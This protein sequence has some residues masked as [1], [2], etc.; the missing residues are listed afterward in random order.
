MTINEPL[1]FIR[2]AYLDR[3]LWLLQKKSGKFNATLDDDHW[4]IG[5]FDEKGLAKGEP[6]KMTRLGNKLNPEGRWGI[7]ISSPVESFVE[8]GRGWVIETQ[9]SV[10]ELTQVN[11]V[12]DYF[13]KECRK[14]GFDPN[15]E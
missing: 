4:L 2:E 11:S 5:L 12:F 6:I 14:V 1:A 3:V 15:R 7:F 8:K 10:Y 13:Y 9:N